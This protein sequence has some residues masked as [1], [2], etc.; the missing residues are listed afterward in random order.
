MG[1]RLDT[2]LRSPMN[3]G[4]I[5][6]PRALV[7]AVLVVLALALV[8]ARLAKLQITDHAH[9]TTLSEENRVKVQ[10]LPPTRGLIYDA[11]GV[12]LADN[13]ASYSLDLTL[14]KVKDRDATIAEL[15]TL[16]PIE[17]KDIRR[18]DRLRAQGGRRFEP[19]PL[20]L[21]LNEEEV[22]R[23]SVNAHRFPGVGIGVQLLRY[24][25]LGVYTAHVLGYVGRISEREVEQLDPAAYSGTNYIGKGGVEKAYEDVLRGQVGYQQVEVNAKG[26][27]LRV[28]AGQSPRSGRDLH[29]H[30]DIAL[31]QAATA[32]LDKFR[33]SVVA[34]DPRNGGVLAMVSTPSFDPN[35]FVEGI[36]SEEYAALRDDPDHP[37]FNR[38]VRGQ[39]PPGS[40]VKPFVALGGLATGIIT[41]GR[42]KFCPGAYQLPGSSHR[43]R[44]WRKGGHGTVGMEQAI[45]QSCD[46]YFY[47][48][49]HDMGID[50]LHEFL[51]HFRFGAKTGVDVS[52]ELPGILPS[53]AWAERTRK[54]PWFAGE[55]VIVGIGQGAFLATPM[56]LAV[57]TAAM[58][59]RGR[60]I[61]PRVVRATNALGAGPE[62]T[63]PPAV[64]QVP[65]PDKYQW[66]DVI[67]GMTQVV[68]RGTAKRIRTPAYKI[69]GKTGTAQVFTVGQKESYRESQV[70]ERMRDHALFVAFAP[71]EAPRIAVAVIVENGGHGGS[72]AAP[73]ARKVMDAYLG[74]APAELDAVEVEDGD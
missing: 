46:V 44:D 49:A 31:Q 38:A 69:A 1:M 53:R 26:R 73:I 41:Y 54:Q 23:I 17:D 2:V 33:G 70:P 55:T 66:R 63:L 45:V 47:D 60:L 74:Q 6:V 4:R 37:L 25:P 30:L 21:N 13:F 36:G 8:L 65:V 28:L 27:V 61:V 20:R 11:K 57:A 56:Q 12:M 35:P 43:Y 51:A 48:L 5:F 29:L 50:R 24:Y 59:N 14:E 58:A 22:A 15:R 39:Y 68:E 52:G 34:I 10:P 71:V 7:A 19:V 62:E 72:V 18:F 9:F 42:A 64:T 40:T 32:A 67:E 3:D 16:I